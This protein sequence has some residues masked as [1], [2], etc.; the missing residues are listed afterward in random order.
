MLH[1]PVQP[2]PH[3]QPADYVPGN[4]DADSPLFINDSNDKTDT[5]EL[6]KR[7]FDP[8]VMNM[9]DIGEL[10]QEECRELYEKMKTSDDLPFE[11]LWESAHGEVLEIDDYPE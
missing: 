3:P 9:F 8:S 7:N 10:S 1:L 6:E 4:T 11:I 5:E 2:L